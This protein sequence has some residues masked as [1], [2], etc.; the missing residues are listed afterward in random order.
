[1]TRNVRQ[2]IFFPATSAATFSY[3]KQ[4][5]DEE[6]EENYPNLKKSLRFWNKDADTYF[7]WPFVLFSAAHHYNK[8]QN[9]KKDVNITDDTIVFIDS[10]GYQ[11]ATGNIPKKYD[12]KLALE[13]SENNGDVF[14]ILDRPLTPGCKFDDHKELSVEAAKFYANNRSVDGTEILNVMSART[15]NEMEIWYNAIKGFPFEGWAHGG[16]KGNMKSI[17]KGILFLWNKGELERDYVMK[18]HIFGITRVDAMLYIAMAQKSLNDMGI[19]VRLMYDSSS[20]Q[21][22]QAY[23]GYFL[24]ARETGLS[25]LKFSNKYDWT[26]MSSEAWLPCSCPVCRNVDSVKE[27]LNSNL[28]FYMLGILHNLWMMIDVKNKWE[29]M[30]YMDMDEMLDGLPTKMKRN[31]LI[32]RKAFYNPKE[33]MEIID[34]EFEDKNIDVGT[35]TGGLE[36]FM[37]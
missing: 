33:G 30:I 13:W 27:F 19:P 15:S 37:Q 34:R 14:P 8:T 36:D 24:F 26:K 7:Y 32:I 4:N 6:L 5:T 22:N 11:K 16:H 2:P 29:S 23:G 18:Y 35:D 9:L 3:L 1:M 10:G 12:E 28:E 20:H 31:V 17:L 25:S 21:Q